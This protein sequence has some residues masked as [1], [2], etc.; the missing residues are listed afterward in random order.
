MQWSGNAACE[1]ETERNGAVA[2]LASQSRARAEPCRHLARREWFGARACP[3]PSASV[4]SVKPR[5]KT[6]I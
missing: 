6:E 4:G 1:I 2:K 3:R 5:G